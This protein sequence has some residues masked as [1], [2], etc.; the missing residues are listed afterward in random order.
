MIEQT[1]SSPQPPS[2]LGGVNF[3]SP[4]KADLLD[5]INP[6]GVVEELKQRLMGREWDSIKEQWTQ[7]PQ[8][9]NISL[10]SAGAFGITTLIFPTSTKNTAMTNLTDEEIK[11]R[12]MSLIRTTMKL[13]L[14]NWKEYGIK[15]ISQ[16]YFIKDVV[17]TSTLVSLKQPENEGVRR[18]LNNIVSENRSLTTFNTEKPGRSIFGLFRKTK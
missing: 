18:L 6:E 12:L 17:Y 7:N 8:L 13:C 3:I 11:K 4:D 15:S 5:K 14:D 2:S 1:T 16:L 10:S 9:I